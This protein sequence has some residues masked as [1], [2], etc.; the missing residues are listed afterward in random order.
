MA[1]DSGNFFTDAYGEI[2]ESTEAIANNTAAETGGTIRTVGQAPVAIVDDAVKTV[3]GL[4]DLPL[5]NNLSINGAVEIFK[6][7]SKSNLNGV[8][9]NLTGF[10]IA[11]TNSQTAGQLIGAKIGSALITLSK[12]IIDEVKACIEQ[13]IL[14]LTRKNPIADLFFFYNYYKSQLLAQITTTIDRAVSKAVNDLF[15]KKIQIQQIAL[16]RQQILN[17]VRKLCPQ[18]SPTASRNY[19]KDP[20][21]ILSAGQSGATNITSAIASQATTPPPP[22]SKGWNTLV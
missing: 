20:T 6:D 8:L 2:S 9:S 10:N 13:Q 14:T 11:S 3:K 17:E 19:T 21:S 7:P 15:Y 18:A 1:F 5:A 4:P 22:A 16:L 12:L